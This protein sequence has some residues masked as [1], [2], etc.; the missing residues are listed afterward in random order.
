[1]SLAV[2]VLFPILFYLPKFFEYRYVDMLVPVTR[3]INCT[4]YALDTLQARWQL[5]YWD[6]QKN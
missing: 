5:V 1:M 6:F 3:E 2:V 4:E